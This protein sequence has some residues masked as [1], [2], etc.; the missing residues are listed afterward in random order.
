M[1]GLTLCRLT[2]PEGLHHLQS[3]TPCKV[4][5]LCKATPAASLYPLQIA[6]PAGLNTLKVFTS[7]GA[8]SLQRSTASRITSAAELPPLQVGVT[9][10]PRLHPVGLHRYTRLLVVISPA[11]LQALTGYTRLL[12]YP[13]QGYNPSIDR[14][15]PLELTKVGRRLYGG[16][17]GNPLST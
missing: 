2:H 14:R 1:Q 6:G 4:T 11:G 5:L 9:S 17:T 7:C 16:E 10:L 3:Y 13:V 12:C 15:I 8:V